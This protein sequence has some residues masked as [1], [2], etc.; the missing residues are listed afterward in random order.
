MIHQ[1]R[2]ETHGA[3]LVLTDALCLSDSP[4]WA[5]LVQHL[6][7][8]LEKVDK[9]R[10][11]CKWT[12]LPL[13]SPVSPMQGR[14]PG[15]KGNEGALIGIIE[16]FGPICLMWW[17]TVERP[18]SGA[19]ALSCAAW[20]VWLDFTPLKSETLNA[21]KFIYFTAFQCRRKLYTKLLGSL[22]RNMRTVIKINF[23][24]LPNSKQH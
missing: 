12:H 16:D 4:R 9:M 21:A 1:V 2:L 14:A 15:T 7:S 11:A 18:G 24:P 20:G 3:I 8:S 22:C 10:P 6:S 5:G 23:H 19:A 13:H 17:A